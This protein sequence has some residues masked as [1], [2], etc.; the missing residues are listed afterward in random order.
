MHR[1]LFLFS[2]WLA[3]LLPVSNNSIKIS[4]RVMEEPLWSNY[5][6]KKYPEI[7][8]CNRKIGNRY[9][10]LK[11]KYTYYI[12]INLFDNE[13]ILPAMIHNLMKL[14]NQYFIPKNVFLRVYESASSDKTKDM[15]HEFHSLLNKYDVNHEIETSPI[16]NNKRDVNRIEHLIKMRNYAMIPVLKRRLKADHVLFLNDILFCYNDMLELIHQQH[17]NKAYLTGGLDF[18]ISPSGSF[19]FYDSWVTQDINGRHGH[20]GGPVLH[21]P[22]KDRVEKNLPV[23]MMCTWNGMVAINATIFETLDMGFR[24]GMNGKKGERTPGECSASE[25]SAL[26]IDMIK[27][28]FGKILM[29]PDVKVSYGVKAYNILRNEQKDIT[30]LFPY[31][32]PQTPE[33]DIPIEWKP[34]GQ[35]Q[36]C[37]PY[38]DGDRGRDK[39]EKGN[40]EEDLPAIAY[41]VSKNES[42]TFLIQ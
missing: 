4:F 3:T 38:F 25:I 11:G 7:H 40:Y 30:N 20:G 19:V 35:K 12:A 27:N 42:K 1:T 2:I 23:Q 5:L 26:C 34:F 32:S 15:L 24:R 14:I 36:D 29:V 37:W 28:G 41:H 21:Q 31:N 9:D 10:Y 18:N 13:E 17:L 16:H 39:I 22:D 6:T 33:N 8:I